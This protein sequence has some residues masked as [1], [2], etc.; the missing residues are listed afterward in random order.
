MPNIFSQSVKHR[1]FFSVDDLL[2][3]RRRKKHSVFQMILDILPMILYIC[4]Y[5]APWFQ[6]S[7]DR[8][9]G[10]AWLSWQP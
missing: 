4:W 5:F 7:E 6:W 1:V 3:F 10:D 2:L 9:S 8:R